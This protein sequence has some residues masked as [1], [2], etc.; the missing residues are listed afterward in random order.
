MLWY[1]GPVSHRGASRPGIQGKGTVDMPSTQ[2]VVRV[3]R[4]VARRADEH[5]VAPVRRE[6]RRHRTPRAHMLHI[7]KTG[8]TAMKDVF[9]ARG[10]EQKGRYEIVL[11]RH[12]TRL[13]GIPRGDKVFFVVRDP[14]DRFVS[15][16]NSRLR[17][18]RPRYDTPWT[19]AERVAFE[20]FPTADS[21]GRALSSEDVAQRARAYTAMISIRHVRDSYWRWFASREYLDTRLDDLLLIQWF[22]DLTPTFAQLTE[23]LG[24]PDSVRLPTDDLRRHK[25]PDTV[26]RRLSAEARRNLESWYGRDYAF[27]DYCA[28]LGCFAGPS[29]VSVEV[30]APGSDLAAGA[31]GSDLE[32]TE[33]ASRP[34]RASQRP[35]TSA[36]QPTASD[37]GSGVIR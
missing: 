28:R 29:R 34:S 4:A 19:E 27:I 26:D 10:P 6:V 25:S 13:P 14:V 30:T 35:P 12:A 33:S 16:F 22:P 20:S 23:L 5:V 32:P 24:L 15:G 7:G 21:L 31:P 8:G 17:R 3:T 36:I 9:K 2:T 1:N 18:G 11:H 37:N